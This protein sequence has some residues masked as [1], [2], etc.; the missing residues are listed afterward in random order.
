MELTKG[1]S[2]KFSMLTETQTRV[3]YT[4]VEAVY[5]GPLGPQSAGVPETCN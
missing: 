5:E 4:R 2:D 1:I 3:K